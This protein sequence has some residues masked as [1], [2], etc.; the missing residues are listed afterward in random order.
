MTADGATGL[1]IFLP[2]H[3][4]LKS[5]CEPPFGWNVCKVL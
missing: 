3:E 2:I 1:L 4:T 5:K